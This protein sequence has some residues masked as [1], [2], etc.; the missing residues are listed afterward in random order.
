MGKYGLMSTLFFVVAIVVMA[1]LLVEIA[2][3]LYFDVDVFGFAHDHG[4]A[5]GLLLIVSV[6]LLL[7]GLFAIIPTTK[8]EDDL[9]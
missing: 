2:V 1:I 5:W 4:F 7:S 9:E 6:C 8:Q 3:G